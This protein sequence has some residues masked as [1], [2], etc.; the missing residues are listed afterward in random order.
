MI[1]KDKA[2]WLSEFY[3]DLANGREGEIR[4][5]KPN[6]CWRPLVS[7]PTLK[8]DKIN[9][10]IKSIPT[11]IDLEYFVGREIDCEFGTTESN[12]WRFGRLARIQN[13]SHNPKS[14]M[15]FYKFCK[16]RMNHWQAYR[17]L[18]RP[19]PEGFIVQVMLGDGS[20]STDTSFNFCWELPKTAVNRI[21]MFRILDLDA[22]YCWPW[23]IEKDAR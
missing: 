10:R 2:R 5:T 23:G 4:D 8:S 19:V 12:T 22:G 16:P 14:S 3:S 21:V 11:P 20:L 1:D 13:N 7:G 9:F 17:G 6:G 15:T 18:S